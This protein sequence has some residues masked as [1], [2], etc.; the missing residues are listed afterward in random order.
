MNDLIKIYTTLEFH[1]LLDYFNQQWKEAQP[2]HK[3]PVDKSFYLPELAPA[4][5]SVANL[6]PPYSGFFDHSSISKAH[7]LTHDKDDRLPDSVVLVSD[8]DLSRLA[9][10][11][12]RPQDGTTPTLDILADLENAVAVDSLGNAYMGSEFNTR[13]TDRL[14]FA[15]ALV[16]YAQQNGRTVDELYELAPSVLLIK[17]AEQYYIFFDSRKWATDSG[18]N[19]ISCLNH[20]ASQDR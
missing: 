3:L 2:D 20:P 9:E 12:I 15:D 13:W 16:R 14:N 4:K 18:Y 6:T 10:R 17:A 19:N 8:D 5:I 7:K 11:R 1:E